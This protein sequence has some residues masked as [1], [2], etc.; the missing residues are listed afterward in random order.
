MSALLARRDDELL[1]LT[2]N[3]P[4]KA[5]A[6]NQEMNDALVAHLEAATADPG[7]RAV[8]LASSGTRCFSAGADLKEFSELERGAAS[9]K[10]RDLLV[11][12]LYAFID[13]P[14][15]LVAALQAQAL[16]GGCMLALLADEIVAADTAQLGMPEIRHGMASPIGLAIIV[17]R[18]GRAV[19]HRLVQAGES[20][21]ARKA[22][23][24]GLVD[25]IVPLAKLEERAVQRARALGAMSGAAFQANK[26]FMNAQL[27]VDLEA[28]RRSA[29]AT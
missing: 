19:G 25:E 3:R 21:D 9:G 18:A 26:S 23:E 27:R 16:G 22:V 17:A 13:F 5:N 2:L 28:A 7:V 20:I 14:K 10:R 24:F 6:M 11:R 15:P 1:L 12:T 4:D 8:V 29:D